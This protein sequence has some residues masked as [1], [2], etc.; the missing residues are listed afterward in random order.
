MFAAHGTGLEKISPSGQEFIL[1]IEADASANGIRILKEAGVANEDLR[2]VGGL[3]SKWYASY[4]KLY[5]K[6]VVKRV[7][8]L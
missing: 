6:E 8:G 1:G 5:Q 7:A 4:E 3:T 2:I